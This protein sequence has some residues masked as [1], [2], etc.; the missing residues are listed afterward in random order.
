VWFDDVFDVQHS[1]AMGT[2]IDKQRALFCKGDGK[3]Q[4][5]LKKVFFA[6]SGIGFVSKTLML[7]IFSAQK[8]NFL[9]KKVCLPI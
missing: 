6:S 9:A 2:T 4:I 7:I 8:F 5:F 1:T 3:T